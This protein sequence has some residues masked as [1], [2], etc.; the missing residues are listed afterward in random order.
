M[1]IVVVGAGVVG[2]VTALTLA[3]AG[4]QVEIVESAGAAATGASFANAGLISP[5]HC[6]SWA[7]PGIGRA[8]LRALL[9]RDEGLGICQPWSA[10]L[11]RWGS[12]FL[13]EGTHERWRANSQAALKLAAYS[14]D[15]LFRSATPAPNA[16]GG[17]QHG[18][19]YLYGEQDHPGPDDATLLHEAGEPFT[20]LDHEQLL[21]QEPM[22]RD[23]D[24]AF[25]RAVHCP[26]D[27][28]GDA[29]RY[30]R[31]ALDEAS[32]LGV[33]IHFDEPVLALSQQ[34]QAVNG[35]TT[36]RQT[37]HADAVIMAAGLT[38]SAL[39]RPLGYRL[40]IY[41]VTGY[42]LSYRPAPAS[43]PRSGAVSIPH[44]IAW[45]AFGDDTMRFTGFAD[46]GIP[47]HKQATARLAQLTEFAHL[48]CPPLARA[49]PSQ[50]IGQ[51]PM[52]PDNL[53]FL[54]QSAH[55]GLWLNCGHSAMGWTMACGSAQI[56]AD[57]LQGRTPAIDLHPYRW[58]R[59]RR[60]SRQGD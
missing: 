9:G 6:F 16:F 43:S 5:G 33:R 12:L 13:R 2:T 37:Y 3:R 60:L 38:S 42:S 29:A 49:T 30:T 10:A 34:G 28:T 57:L 7:E 54:G 11:L 56:I 15:Q 45:A 50:W 51:R 47:S 31:A 55:P 17:H 4:H 27:G 59:Y 26:N 22:L 24:I 32:A 39:L 36:A 21:A 8:A 23:A 14:R 46:I 52:T 19:L 44:K 40:P 58:N 53:P 1:H 25:A 20:A 18:I 48:V 41:P 35:V